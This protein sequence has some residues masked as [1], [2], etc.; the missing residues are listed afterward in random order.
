MPD[1][2]YLNAAIGWLG[3]GDCEEAQRELDR[4][5]PESGTHPDVM[6]VRAEI[7]GRHA[8]WDKVAEAAQRLR[9]ISPEEAQLWITLAYATRRMPGGGIEDAKKILLDAYRRFPKE[10]IIA[11]NLACYECQL[12]DVATARAWLSQAMHLGDVKSMRSM[13]L[14]DSDLEPMWE[15]IREAVS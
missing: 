13:A 10:P 1:G 8:Q 15:E 6:R 9:E 5:S 11:Y 4:I 14:A 7:Y 3:L 2:H 12:G